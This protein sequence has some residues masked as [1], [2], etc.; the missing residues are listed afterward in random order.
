MPVF[1]KL[2]TLFFSQGQLALFFQIFKRSIFK[3]LFKKDISYKKSEAAELV[4]KLLSGYMIDFQFILIPRILSLLIFRR[5]MN[6]Y[7]PIFNAGCNFE[8]SEVF[9]I[10]E[11]MAC[12]VLIIN[13]SITIFILIW[14]YRK[15]KNFFVYIPER[16]NVL[17]RAYVLLMVHNYFEYV[18]QEIRYNNFE[19]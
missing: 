18:L 10:R 9:I 15:N 11:E 2:S 7:I 13:F 1:P 6:Y 19:P 17:K 3:F 4:D 12:I 16:I 14:M 5:W 8:I